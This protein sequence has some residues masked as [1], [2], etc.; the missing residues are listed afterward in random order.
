MAS[1]NKAAA[2]KKLNNI[3]VKGRKGKRLNGIGQGKLPETGTGLLEPLWRPR[4]RISYYV[5]HATNVFD[6][7]VIGL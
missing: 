1:V 4:Q 5:V 6:A 3:N 7:Q 2:T